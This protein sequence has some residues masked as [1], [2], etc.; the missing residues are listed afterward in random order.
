M[1]Q[2]LERE[3]EEVLRRRPSTPRTELG[4]ESSLRV[5]AATLSRSPDIAATR[6]VGTLD[7]DDVAAVESLVADIA[8]EFGLE[9]RL[10]IN[11][12]SF[13]VRFSRLE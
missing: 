8:Y 12:G 10:R 5:A 1:K 4:C 9:S 6:V 11:A 7:Q 2:L 13:S 3:L